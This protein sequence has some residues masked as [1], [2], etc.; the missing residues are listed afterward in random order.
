MRSTCAT[1]CSIIGNVKCLGC[2][3]SLMPNYGSYCLCKT[4]SYI[5]KTIEQR[6]AVNNCETEL[7]VT[8][9][10][11]YAIVSYNTILYKPKIQRLFLRPTFRVWRKETGQ[12]LFYYGR[13]R[14]VA[15][16][17]AKLPIHYLNLYILFRIYLLLARNYTMQ[18]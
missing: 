10:M 3:K 11:M 17:C 16:M 7:R 8:I 15:L 9:E 13:V 14:A 5:K 2:R 6:K 18:M 4:L 1:A 12:L